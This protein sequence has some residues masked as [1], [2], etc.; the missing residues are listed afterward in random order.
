MTLSRHIDEEGVR[1]EPSLLVRQ[2]RRNEQVLN[3]LLSAVRMPSERLGDL[4]RNSPPIASGRWR[5]GE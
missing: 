5:C 4:T 2:G 1:I 3:R